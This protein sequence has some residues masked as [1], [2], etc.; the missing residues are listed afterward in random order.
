MTKATLIEMWSRIPV[1]FR[2]I[3]LGILICSAAFF[4]YRILFEKTDP[5]IKTVQ[6]D[7]LIKIDSNPKETMKLP[8]SEE[9]DA[10]LEKILKE[11]E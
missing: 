10:T 2:G 3:L 5:Y 1:I 11:I 9:L 6:K 4:A 7:D 8:K